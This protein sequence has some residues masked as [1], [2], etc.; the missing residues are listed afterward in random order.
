MSERN[1]PTLPKAERL[2]ALRNA[3]LPA[4]LARALDADPDLGMAK[5][6]AGLAERDR[7]RG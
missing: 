5:R 1:A 4:H 3:E 7:E 2:K 6:P